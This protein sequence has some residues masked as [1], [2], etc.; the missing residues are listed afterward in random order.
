MT[1]CKNLPQNQPKS[2]RKFT[3]EL[4]AGRGAL[5]M[6]LGSFASPWSAGWQVKSRGLSRVIYAF[7]CL[8]LHYSSCPNFSVML[9]PYTPHPSISHVL[10][11]CFLIPLL[12]LSW[13]SF[14][15]PHAELQAVYTQHSFS[16]G[17]PR[18]TG[19]KFSPISHMLILPQ[20]CSSQDSL[21]SFP[22]VIQLMKNHL[23]ILNLYKLHWQKCFFPQV[24]LQVYVKMN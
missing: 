14:R 17:L 4:F 21:G 22:G 9:S 23:F 24:K 3:T 1:Q 5:V 13:L 7:A 8:L 12:L 6:G 10:A 16:I 18:L 20:A 11:L 15:V 19:K 2:K